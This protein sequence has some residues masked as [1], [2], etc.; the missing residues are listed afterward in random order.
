MQP[1]PA[2]SAQLEP[3]TN[4]QSVT[5]IA[6]NAKTSRGLAKVAGNRRTSVSTAQ[7]AIRSQNCLERKRERTWQQEPGHVTGRRRRPFSQAM[8]R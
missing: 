8:L 5:N 3:L 4:L 1:S 2:I 7:S 6:S